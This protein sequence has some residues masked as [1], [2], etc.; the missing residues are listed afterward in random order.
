MKGEKETQNEEKV[1]TICGEEGVTSVAWRGKKR[2]S[3]CC[4][5]RV[6]PSPR[7]YEE[8]K[9]RRDRR[10]GAG[11]G[12][13]LPRPG[14]GGGKDKKKGCQNPERYESRTRPDVM[15]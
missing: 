10:R 13:C 12:L 15:S 7:T 2:N 5:L 1:Q 9:H 3:K 4:L 6:T 14:W 8:G 11:Q